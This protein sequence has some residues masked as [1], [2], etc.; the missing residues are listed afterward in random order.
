[1]PR[2]QK[3]MVSSGMK[4]PGNSWQTKICRRKQALRSASGRAPS[5]GDSHQAGAR[6]LCEPR[7]SGRS[8]LR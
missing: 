2:R 8:A 6:R 4:T 7:R 3:R 5:W 1:M